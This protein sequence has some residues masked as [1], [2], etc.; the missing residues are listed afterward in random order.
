ME[1]IKGTDFVPMT[2]DEVIT[3]DTIKL[4]PTRFAPTFKSFQ[5]T[6]SWSL[7]VKAKVLCAGKE[8]T[9]FSLF[10]R[11]ALLSPKIHSDTL[12]SAPDYDKVVVSSK[13]EVPAY[14]S[15]NLTTDMKK[16]FNPF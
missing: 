13:G 7:H 1:V 3:L 16:A 15:S 2:L 11:E 10:E 9:V 6:G 5:M 8:F 12:D 4:D 14:E